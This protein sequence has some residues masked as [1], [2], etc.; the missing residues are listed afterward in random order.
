M[1]QTD[2]LDILHFDV[3]EIQKGIGVLQAITHHNLLSKI[4]PP[5]KS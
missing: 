4:P 3:V 1:R 2:R 5:L